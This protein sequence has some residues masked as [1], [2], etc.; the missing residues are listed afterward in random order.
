MALSDNNSGWYAGKIIKRLL[1]KALGR[2]FALGL[3]HQSVRPEIM[4]V[5]VQRS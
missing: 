2:R 5:V 1:N 4:E 3:V